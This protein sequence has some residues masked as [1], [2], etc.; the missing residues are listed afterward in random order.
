MGEGR[1]FLWRLGKVLKQQGEDI[2]REPLPE[3]WDEIV[4]ALA[5]RERKKRADESEKK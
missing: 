2:T 1:G 3:R 5:E 4:R